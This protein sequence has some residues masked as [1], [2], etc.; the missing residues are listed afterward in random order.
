MSRKN[1]TV[2]GLVT[3]AFTV[4]LLTFAL[5]PAAN[6]TTREVANVAGPKPAPTSALHSAPN[7]T[8]EKSL[9]KAP[10]LKMLMRRIT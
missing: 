4:L 9:K 7:L 5:R 8:Q 6:G 2:A 3:A 10:Y 1:L